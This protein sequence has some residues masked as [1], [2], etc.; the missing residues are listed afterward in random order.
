[1]N[2]AAFRTPPSGPT[3]SER[4]WEEAYLKVKQSSLKLVK[5]FEEKCLPPGQSGGAQKVAEALAGKLRHR[6]AEQIVIKIRQQEI[7]LREQ[8]E[9]IVKFVMWSSDY[10]GSLARLEPHAAIAWAGVSL[11]LPVGWRA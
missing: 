1:M 9:N 8:G 11:L 5:D 3:L 7:N 6:D 2:M 10:V 4:L